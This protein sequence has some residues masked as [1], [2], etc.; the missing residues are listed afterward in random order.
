MKK[1]III[2]SL[3]KGGAERVATNLLKEKIFDYVIIFEENLNSYILPSQKIINIKIHSTKNILKKILNFFLR[4]KKIKKIKKELKAKISLSM[5]DTPNIL[6]VITKENDKVIISFRA[7]YS[8]TFMEEESL[9]PKLIRVILKYLYK[10]IISYIYNNS[11]LMIAVSN[12]V[13]KD[14][15]DNFRIDKSK[16]KVIYNP[17]LLDEINKLKNEDL[18]HY[19]DIFKNPVLITA[20]RLTKQK[21]QWHLIRVFKMV[22]NEF[23]NLKLVIIGNGELKNYLINLSNEL[24]MK[25]YIWEQNYLH[26]KYDVYFLGIQENPYKFISKS[27]IFLLSSLWEGFPNVI[28]ESMACG[29]PVISSDCKGGPREILA[30]K[31]DFNYQTKSPEFA[32]YGILMPVPIKDYKKSEDNFDSTEKIWADFLIKIFKDDK[33]IIDYS[34]KSLI[35]AKDFD[36]KV[37]AKQ[38]KNF[39]DK[40]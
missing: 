10:Y 24:G 1:I 26:D 37:I 35:R 30:P 15:I 5:L 33:I 28:L 9:G 25:T 19:S 20:G 14:L 8:L 38:W 27:K 29:T 21:S 12:S 16:I 32:E 31:T 40:I 4:Y 17:L 23:S 39:F 34:K 3:A 22:K 2:N 7:H 6:N 18:K 11:D 36:I 13:K